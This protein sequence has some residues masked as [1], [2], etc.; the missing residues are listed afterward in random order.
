[1]KKLKTFHQ[2]LQH[3]LSGHSQGRQLLN[4]RSEYNAEDMLYNNLIRCMHLSVNV[5]LVFLLEIDEII[6][7]LS[8]LCVTLITS[9]TCM[10]VTNVL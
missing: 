6:V 1:M 2:I 9:R 3:T 10:I 5:V 4:S 7:C 8:W